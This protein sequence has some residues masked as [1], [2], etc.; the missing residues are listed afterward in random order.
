[1]FIMIFL[2]GILFLAGLFLSP[3]MSGLLFL[4]GTI[5]VGNIFLSL[6]L[7][8][9]PKPIWK[10]VANTPNFIF[11][12]ITGLFKMGNPNKNFKASEHKHS[13]SI[14]EILKKD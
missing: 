9:V 10:A 12:Q 7:S 5:F 3:V 2:A 8:K 4:G 14:D 11:N 1:M 13:V 6:Y